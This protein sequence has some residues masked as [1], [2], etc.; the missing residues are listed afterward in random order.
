MSSELPVALTIATSDSGAGAGVQADLLTFA[1]RGVYGVS[2]FAA[3]TAQNPAG[4]SAIHE[5][6]ADFL[7]A[8]LDQLAAYYRIRALKTGML[9]S[10]PLIRATAHFIERENIP[11]VVDPVMVATSGAV[12]L[13]P[14]AI[15]TLEEE[16][17]PRA[18][19]IT[20]N[21]DEA[22]VLLGRPVGKIAELAA[23]AQELSA[24]YGTAV[25]LKGG[26]LPGGTLIDT[27]AVPG[28]EP[29]RFTSKRIENVNTHGSGCTLSAAI[30]AGLAQ[31]LGLAD[32]VAAAHA[33]LQAAMNAPLRVAGENFISHGVREDL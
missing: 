17:L 29:V 8:Q 3:L 20:P 6:P 21:L 27:L 22:A 33:Y 15:A 23:T 1:A 13:R 18:M 28:Q 19:L 10:A 14:E 7:Q 31:G 2:A 4:V 9:F 24:R 12:L 5:L 16:L 11:A 26:H 25:L 30:A 32:A